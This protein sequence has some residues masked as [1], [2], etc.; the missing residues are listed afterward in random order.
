MVL[1]Q[2]LCRNCSASH[3]F[4]LLCFL[5][6]HV[7]N[8]WGNVER[9][10]SD[11]YHF[12]VA[13]QP[14]WIDLTSLSNTSVTQSGFAIHYLL[15]EWQTRVLDDDSATEAFTRIIYSPVSASGVQEA[16]EISID[17]RPTYEELTIHAV[18]ITRDGTVTQRLQANNVKLIQHERNIDKHLYNG[19]VT[20]LLVLGDIRVGDIIEYSYTVKGR[21]PVFSGKYFNAFPLGW[22]VPV[23]RVAVRIILPEHR[24]LNSRSYNVELTSEEFDQG[25]NHIYRW[26]VDN[27][28]SLRSEDGIPQWFNPY[29]WLQVTEYNNWQEV[30]HWAEQ[31]YNQPITLSQPLQ[32]QIAAWVQDSSDSDVSIQKALAFVQDK[33]HYFGVEMGTNSHMPS[34]P[35]ETFERRYGDCKDK[36]VLLTAILVRMGFTA[37]PALVSIEYSRAIADWLPSPGAFDHV[38]VKADINGET[39]WIDATRT[40]QRGKLASRGQPD[41]GHALVVGDAVSKLEAIDLPENYLPSAVIEEK[42]IASNYDGPVDLIVTSRFNFSEAESR[43]QYFASQPLKDVQENY[44]NFY[45]RFYPGLAPVSDIQLEDD[46]QNNILTVIEHYRIPDYWERKDGKLYS[47]FHGTSIGDYTR[48][49]RTVNRKMPLSL[50][51]PLHVQHSAILEFPDEIGFSHAHVQEEVVDAGM[52][53]VISSSYNNRQLRVDYIYDS[54]LDAVMPDAMAEHMANRRKI[55]ASLY[56]SAWV[57]DAEYVPRQALYQSPFDTS[58]HIN[59]HSSIGNVQQ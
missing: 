30:S 32:D 49:P 41:Y 39:R 42:F 27:T 40:L 12:N 46:E 53:F 34:H 4:V 9:F 11:R 35:N 7:L 45:A 48:L 2:L 58:V 23:D 50:N 17:F 51:Y 10:E 52:Q 57:A 29:P 22:K 31:L 33:V 54:L 18:S 38:I 15:S 36:A 5:T 19:E 20:A 59:Q 1:I 44:V 24:Q 43:R 8:V 28:Q 14:E 37:N 6:L 21:N 47:N 55:N 25:G 56:F 16:A 13:G 26:V 3:Q